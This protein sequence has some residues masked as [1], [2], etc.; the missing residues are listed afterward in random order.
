MS[1]AREVFTRR[2]V[3]FIL[4]SLSAPMKPRVSAFSNR[5]IVATSA[6]AR[7]SSMVTHSTPI[8]AAFSGVRLRDQAITFMPKACPTFA[9]S[10]PMRPRPMMPR[11]LPRTP[12]PTEVCQPPAASEATSFGRLRMKARII[13]QVS[14]AVG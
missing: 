12:M 5:W 11:V 8:T 10:E 1:C 9:T 4:A 6:R 13:V 3:D 14:S 7:S 2:A